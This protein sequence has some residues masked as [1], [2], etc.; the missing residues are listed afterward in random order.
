MYV[1]SEE[2]KE[3]RPKKHDKK[4]KNKKLKIKMN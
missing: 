2:S 4:N 3:R 1:H